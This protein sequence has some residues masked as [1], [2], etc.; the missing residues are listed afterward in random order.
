MPRQD[1]LNYATKWDH[2]ADSS[3][4]DDEQDEF[5]NASSR[6]RPRVTRL[7]QPSTITTGADGSVTIAVPHKDPNSAATTTP[8]ES[9]V[10][11]KTVDLSSTSCSLSHVPS[12]WTEKGACIVVESSISDHVSSSEHSHSL[13][14]SCNRYY[15]SQDRATVV[16]RIP[17]DNNSNNNNNS[18]NN[19]DN[20]KWDCCVESILS[21][22]DRQCGVMNS[23]H[24][25]RLVVQCTS[26]NSASPTV[27]LLQGT[28]SHPVH[29][30][31]DDDTVDW[32]IEQDTTVT[33]QPLRYLCVT[34]YKATPMAG[35]AI[36]WKKL[37]QQEPQEIVFDW[38]DNTQTNAF[39]QAW[40]T[41]HEQFRTKVKNAE[42]RQQ[43][44]V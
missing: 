43:H 5:N 8:V 31:E 14:G 1:S 18:D 11:V 12:S 37:L 40:E 22:R 38:M 24:P 36:W 32:S 29:L 39:Q 35:L 42:H 26:S 19:N 44:L 21:Y 33:T 30:A 15:W 13:V 28:L 7:D 17:I 9:A 34:L 27:V 16:V 10:A 4:D 41:A 6:G 25:Q 2:I 3:D 20:S 23:E